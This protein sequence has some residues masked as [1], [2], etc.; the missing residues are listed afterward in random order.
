MLL[1]RSI[2][3]KLSLT[4]G[5]V[6]LMFV[7]FGI[8]SIRSLRA[9]SR[10]IRNLETSVHET[11]HRGELVAAF[12]S[13]V[14]PLSVSVPYDPADPTPWQWTAQRQQGEFTKRLEEAQSSIDRFQGQL[15]SSGCLTELS[16]EK[17]RELDLLFQRIDSEFKLFEEEARNL[18]QPD[19][20]EASIAWMLRSTSELIDLSSQMPDPVDH[21]IRLLGE[22]RADYE[23]HR[24]LVLSL[25]VVSLLMFSFVSTMGYHW[26][27]KPLRELHQDFQTVANG[28]YSHRSSVSTNDELASLA[29]AFNSVTSRFQNEVASREQEISIQ[30]RKL[31]QSERVVNV[32]FLAA[33]VAHDLN[34]PLGIMAA[35]GEAI[36]RQFCV[37]MAEWTSGDYDMCREYSQMISSNVQRCQRMT[38]RLLD[39]AHGTNAERNY[40]DLTAIIRDVVQTAEHMGKYRDRKIIFD[41]AEPCEAYV[42]GDE[43]KQVVL[44]LV[45]NALQATPAG[46]QLTISM[47]ETTE[48][49]EMVFQD[50]GCGMTPE[51]LQNLFDPF[52]T[53]KE[54]GQGTGL[55][56]SLTRKMIESHGGTITASSEGLSKGSTFRVQIPKKPS[57]L[58][59][60]V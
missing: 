37:P 5:L 59:R 43:I 22:S 45:A 14:A 28:D 42:S 1:T 29:Q 26:F 8:S 11:P 54:V 49:V 33:G 7:I 31:I 50:T 57:P 35:C 12:G 52:F 55:G 21:L 56:L 27:F 48:Q 10:M 19:K 15:K 38:H 46:G 9:Y 40:Y 18:T 36:E 39:F 53:T 20:H 58:N 13:F 16:T 30:A 44:N 51:I 2:R 41:R 60:L 32:G 17:Q 4:L 6:F 25:G 47:T 3:R 24:R 34:N 23:S